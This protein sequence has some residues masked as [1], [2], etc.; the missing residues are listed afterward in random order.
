MRLTRQLQQ[1]AATIAARPSGHEVE[2]VVR[3]RVGAFMASDRHDLAQRRKFNNWLSTLGVRILF[4]GP[5]GFEDLTV[6]LADGSVELH[7]DGGEVIDQADGRP[8]T[9]QGLPSVVVV[10]PA[11]AG[12]IG[13]AATIEQSRPQTA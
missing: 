7:Y 10:D 8:V 9:V 1:Q 2:A 4:D 5:T 11:V 13:S 6:E 12:V 3:E